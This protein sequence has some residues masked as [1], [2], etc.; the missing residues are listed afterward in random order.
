MCNKKSFTFIYIPRTKTCALVE[1]SYERKPGLEQDSIK[2]NS[3]NSNTKI[4]GTPMFAVGVEERRVG[5]RIRTGL[6]TRSISS[7]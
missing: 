3:Q 2:H 4:T 5:C 7:I 1:A 6:V